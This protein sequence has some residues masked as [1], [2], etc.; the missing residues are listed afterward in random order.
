MVSIYGIIVVVSTLR[1]LLYFIFKF[2]LTISIP[3]DRFFQLF[4]RETKTPGNAP[5]CRRNQKGLDS[6]KEAHKYICRN[7]CSRLQEDPPSG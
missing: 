7:N 2:Q 6:E 5:Y 3:I 4:S 1:I